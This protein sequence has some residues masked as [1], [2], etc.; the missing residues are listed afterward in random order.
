MTPV[1]PL[2][3]QQRALLECL[4]RVPF[5]QA[6]DLARELAMSRS[7]VYRCLRALLAHGLLEQVI[8]PAGTTTRGSCRLYTISPAGQQLVGL[9]L[10][11]AE[12]PPGRWGLSGRFLR[13][14]LPRLDRLAFGQAAV[15]SLLVQAPHFFARQGSVAVVRWTWIRDYERPVPGKRAPGFPSSARVFADWLLVLRVRL[16]DDRQERCYPLFVLLDAACFSSQVI[17]QRLLGLL[18]LRQVLAHMQILAPEH[19]PP[20]LVLLPGW[21][22][23]WRWQWQ[24][25]A[26]VQTQVPPLRG[27]LTVWSVPGTAAHPGRELDLWQRPW[28]SLSPAGP[29]FLCDLLCSLAPQDLPA[30]WLAAVHHQHPGGR[31]RGARGAAGAYSWSLVRRAGHVDPAQSSRRTFELPGLSLRRM[32]YHLLELLLATPLLSRTNLEAFLKIQ[33]DSVQRLL[34]TVQARGCLVCEVL[35]GE[36]EL[37]YS[38]SPQGLR[39]LALR[40]RLQPGE[41]AFREGPE[42]V[43]LAGLRREMDALRQR[44]SLAIAVYAFFTRL[45]QQAA[46]RSDHCLLWWERGDLSLSSTAG[47]WRLPHGMGEYQVRERRLRFWLDWQE[48]WSHGASMKQV[49]EG[50]ATA[51]QALQW[52][53]EGAPLVLLVCPGRA[54]EHQVQCFVQSLASPASPGLQI[55]TTTRELLQT[56]GPLARIWQTSGRNDRCHWYTG[57]WSLQRE[58][59]V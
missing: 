47:E 34:T 33:G 14:L 18:R 36:Q 43:E 44:A 20:A 41:V 39:L 45:I 3:E 37:R 4:L 57:A 35:P 28:R 58:R 10:A 29:V 53:D 59:E 48:E 27:G 12:L 11:E 22:R 24:A 56:R 55:F 49:L 9:T 26:L 32:H 16:A 15:H 51:V 19:F 46:C 25:A 17:G 21:Q 1:F 52:R 50:Y 7:T 13:S 30:G 31:M 5:L 6:R 8:R 40:H 2:A 23:A 38:L 42:S 54:R